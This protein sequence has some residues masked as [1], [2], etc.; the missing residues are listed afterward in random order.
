LDE[1]FAGFE[2]ADSQEAFME[3][4]NNIY[5]K[6]L[7]MEQKQMD[8]DNAYSLISQM[9]EESREY[10]RQMEE[11]RIEQEEEA[12]RLWDAQ[13]EESKSQYDQFRADFNTK[14][15]D[16]ETRKGEVAAMPEGQDKIDAQAELDELQREMQG[17]Q[18][19]ANEFQ[20]ANEAY[21]Q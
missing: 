18:V 9:E 6:T 14:K 11:I 4:D 15:A 16:F 12:A 17:Y 3:L 10:D 19:K 2:T 20:K 5:N 13:Y 1:W 8:L 7:E 21:A